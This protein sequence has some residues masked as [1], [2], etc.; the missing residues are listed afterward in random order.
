MEEKIIDLL[1]EKFTEPEFSNCFWLDVKLHAGKKLE[2]I[3]DCD[4]GVTFT[5]CRQI[6]R[7]LESVIDEEQWLGPKYTLEVSSPGTDRPLQLPRQYKKHL[8]RKLVVKTKGGDE[9]E[10]RLSE[11]TEEAITLDYK[12]R[13]KEGK[14]KVTEEVQTT[15]AFDAIEK[16]KVKISFK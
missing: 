3:I 2:I 4:T 7:H 13:R 11:I 1:E 16:A 12:V 9:Y 14:R 6:S 10:G 8:G 15:I 5:T